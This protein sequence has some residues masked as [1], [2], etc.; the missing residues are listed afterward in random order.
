[1]LKYVVGSI[2]LTEEQIAIADLNNDGELTVI[3]AIMLQKLI[4][5]AV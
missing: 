1:M 5:E 2:E 3:D 4:L